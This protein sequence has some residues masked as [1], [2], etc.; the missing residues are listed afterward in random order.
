M[1]FFIGSDRKN[2][3]NVDYVARILKE[4]GWEHTYD[5]TINIKD[6][7]I[8]LDSKEK[9]KKVAMS[10]YEGIKNADVVI[11][12]F[13]GGKG[14][15]VELGISI[16]LNKNIEVWTSDESIYE[17]NQNTSSFYWTDYV[18][19]NR[20]NIEKFVSKLLNNY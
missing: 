3:E 2:I 14:T 4:N 13:P 1:K 7:N 6:Y 5:W 10:A 8:K 9:Q 19:H 20:V 11:L 12:L 17:F 18:K 16:A 15:H